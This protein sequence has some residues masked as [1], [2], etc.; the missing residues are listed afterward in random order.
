MT[1][2]RRDAPPKPTLVELGHDVCATLLRLVKKGWQ[3][4]SDHGWVTA[5]M[6]EVPMT[7][8]LRDA[9]RKVVRDRSRWKLAI[10]A[11][12]ETRSS[13]SVSHP[14]GRTDISVFLLSLFEKYD[15]HDHHAIIECKRVAGSDSSLCRLFV[16]EGVD[17]F[18]TGKY[19]SR[20]VTGFMVGYVQHGSIDAA[21]SAINRQLRNRGRASEE[22][23]ACRVLPAPWTQS[24]RHA[25]SRNSDI[26]LH[27]AFLEFDPP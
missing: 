27:H 21:C 17:R 22:L 11:G 19:S 3:V 20:H 12:T 23:V 4:A 25:R 15:E 6:D 14:D 24:S 1:I 9:M 2:R 18:V 26:D 8:R 16:V 10:R 5:D 7:E 13:R